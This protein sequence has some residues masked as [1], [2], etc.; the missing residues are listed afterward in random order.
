[1]VNPSSKHLTDLSK[2]D[3]K[4]FLADIEYIVRPSAEEAHETED[5]GEV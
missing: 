5:E 2:Q 4:D 3:F 1:M